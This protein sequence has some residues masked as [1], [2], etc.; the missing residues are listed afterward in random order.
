MKPIATATEEAAREHP[1]PTPWRHASGTR[2]ADPFDPDGPRGGFTFDPRP[3]YSD[4]PERFISTRLDA[5]RA[6]AEA[7]KAHL[8][9]EDS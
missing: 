1:D 7:V 4:Y 3:G 2:V 5:Y 9:K 8:L 6:A